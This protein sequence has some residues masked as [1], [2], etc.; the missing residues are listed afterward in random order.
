MNVEALYGI[1]YIVAGVILAYYWFKKEFEEEYNELSK[2][3]EVE[4]GMAS[5]L[6]LIMTVLWPLKL[7]YNLVRYRR[8]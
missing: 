7:I 2:T 8:V 5:I 4:N 3:G 6:L 1:A